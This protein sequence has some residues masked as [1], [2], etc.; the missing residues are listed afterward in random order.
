MKIL[1]VSI[2]LLFTILC[3]P[4][5]AI[6]LDSNNLIDNVIKSLDEERENWIIRGS[7]V[8]YI[9]G[10]IDSDLRN[11]TWPENDKNCV[12]YI[13]FNI[14]RPSPKTGYISFEKPID[15]MVDKNDDFTRLSTKLRQV[16]YEELHNRYGIRMPN[17]QIENNMTINPS[18]E[19]DDGELSKSL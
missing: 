8:Y 6:N 1:I 16:I 7:K 11:E 17:K 9:N 19:K 15:F 18:I 5:Y 3:L 13:S 10:S 2:S 14:L 12:V 4:V